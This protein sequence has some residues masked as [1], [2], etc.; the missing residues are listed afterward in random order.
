MPEPGGAAWVVYGVLSD[1]EVEPLGATTVFGQ[2]GTLGLRRQLP[3]LDTGAGLHSLTL[4]LDFKRTRQRIQS[5][6]DSLRVPLS[7]LPLSFAYSGNFSD[8][9]TSTQ[10]NATLTFGLRGLLQRQVACPDVLLDQFECS[11]SGADAGFGTLRADLRHEFGLGEGWRIAARLAAQVATQPLVSAEQFVA[12]GADT[13]RGYLEAEA[14]GDHGL[15]G[16]LELRTP[17]LAP[18]AGSAFQDLTLSAFADVAR[19]NLVDPLPG[20]AARVPLASLGA[21]LRARLAQRY[22]AALDLAWPVKRTGASPDQRPR[23]QFRL[24]AQY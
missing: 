14:A 22:T 15:L 17:N 7:Y 4:G 2:G 1:S 5:G 3:L 20:Q 11:R 6:D 16:S 24:G 21:G 18:Q 9:A 23:L 13:V 12:G 10:L 8:K 19:V